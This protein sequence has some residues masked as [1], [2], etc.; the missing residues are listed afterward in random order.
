MMVRFGGYNWYIS[1]SV[2][3][4]SKGFSSLLSRTTLHRFGL[5]VRRL[6]YYSYTNN[7]ARL[8]KTRE[9]LYEDLRLWRTDVMK[10]YNSGPGTYMSYSLRMWNGEEYLVE[11]HTGLEI[12]IML[13][14]AVQYVNQTTDLFKDQYKAL[15]NPKVRFILDNVNG[16]ANYFTRVRDVEI[17]EYVS[18]ITTLRTALL[19]CKST[20][21]ILAFIFSLIVPY[22]SYNSFLAR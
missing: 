1:N 4:K 14:N 5:H 12:S 16:V 22:F 11:K 20:I 13:E 15:K 19:S 8:T 10:L 18:F 9:D 7:T 6:N 3:L 17:E 21:G 2:A